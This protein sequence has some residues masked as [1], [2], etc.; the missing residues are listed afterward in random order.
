MARNSTK[1]GKLVRKF[2]QNIFGN[3]KY[4]RLLKKKSKP[5]GSQIRRGR[6][7]ISEFGKQLLEKQ[8]LKF[9]YGLSERQFR[10]LFFK[11]KAKDGVTGETMLVM[12]EQRLDSVVYRSGFACSKNQARQL[13]T[14]GQFLLN[15]RRID[16]PSIQ[17]RPGDVLKVRPKKNV[18]ELSRRLLAENSTREVPDW[19]QV[20]PDDLTIVVNKLPSKEAIPVIAEVQ[21]VVEYYSK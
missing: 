6:K 19:L 20:S 16:I 5:P 13:V 2:G 4:D 14:H 8:K 18:V 1:R 3:P 9:A 17:V 10:N 7:R 11:A 21:L 12:L 15:D